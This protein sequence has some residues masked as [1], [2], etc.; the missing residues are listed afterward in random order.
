MMQLSQMQAL[1]STLTETHQSAIADQ[2]AAAW[3]HDN[4]VQYFRA[5]ANFI[6]TFCNAEQR[7][8][9][10]FAHASDRSADA[11]RAEL[12]FL[13]HLAAH[14]VLVALPV[15]SLSG[16]YLETIATPLG[17]M[18]AVV[19]EALPGDQFETSLSLEQYGVWGNALGELHLASQGYAQ[20]NRPTIDDLLLRVDQL[21]PAHENAARRML[22]RL[23]HQVATLPRSQQTFGLIHYDFELDNI[24]WNGDQI[25][26]IDFDDCCSCWFAADIAFALRDLF[27][28]KPDQID[29]ADERVQAFL[30]GYSRNRNIAYDELLNLPLFLRIHN[31]V[32]FVNLLHAADAKD[33]STTPPWVTALQAKLLRKMQGYHDSFLAYQG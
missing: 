7:F 13:Q 26:I 4:G 30:S 31:L 23:Q 24:L 21:L 29:Y 3:A 16:H 11:I 15:L 18:H 19:F 32:S 27:D 17:T 1:V 9:L 2:I 6:F 10:R 8:V 28:D 20:A 25:G 33:E 5:S 12:A 14:G 22:T